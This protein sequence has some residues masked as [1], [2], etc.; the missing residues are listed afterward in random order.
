MSQLDDDMKREVRGTKRAGRD[1]VLSFNDQMAQD[2]GIVTSRDQIIDP[3]ALVNPENYRKTRAGQ[4]QY[5]SD[6]KQ[7][8]LY[9]EQQ[10]ASYLEWYNSPEQQAIRDREAG[11]NPDLAGLSGSQ[12]VDTQQ[13]PNSPIAGMPTNGQMALDTVNAVMNVIQTATS[14]AS[15]CVGL[16]NLGKQGKLLDAQID[17]TQ[18]G[19]ITSFEQLAHNAIAS[20]F[21]TFHAAETAADRAVDVA[22]WFADDSN[23]AD[24]IPSYAPSD[25]PMYQHALARVRKGSESVLSKAYAT[26]VET[27]EGQQSFAKV[28]AN[29]YADPSTVVMASILEPTMAALFKMEE[30]EANFRAAAADF[31][32][33]AMSGVDPVEVGKVWFGTM[34]EEY[35][36]QRYQN[37]IDEA[38]STVYKNLKSTY[39]NAPTSPAGQ[40][41]AMLLLGHYQS[42]LEGLLVNYVTMLLSEG[43]SPVPV[44]DPEHTNPP[45]STGA[46]PGPSTIR[47]FIPPGS[48]RF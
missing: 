40:T 43:T 15:F 6:L 8:Q 27:A 23:F 42:T 20:K 41:A 46:S 47:G 18:L 9:A 7:A 37:I 33:S 48:V 16:P 39:L 14:V 29:P 35:K 26:N 13:D 19:N 30:S 44:P 24:I 17:S 1:Q 25:N 32:T 36:N 31:K 21:A 22:K 12:G 2:I 10:E 4:A 45:K 34:E 11:L 3:F 38:K 28:L 5:N